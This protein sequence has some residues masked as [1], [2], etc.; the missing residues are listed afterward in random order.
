MEKI[1]VENF[2]NE[3]INSTSRSAI[4]IYRAK[5]DD[6]QKQITAQNPDYV[7]IISLFDAT[8]ILAGTTTFIWKLCI[9][10][11]IAVVTYTIGIFKFDKKD[12]PL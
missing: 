10:L 9:L 5:V 2:T 7:S 3:E 1:E 11:A 6:K 8:S 4:V 12:L